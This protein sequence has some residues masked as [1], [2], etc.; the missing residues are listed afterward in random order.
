MFRLVKW[1]LDVMADDGSAAIVYAAWMDWGRM[2]ISYASV[3]QSPSSGP[4]LEA[5]T[6]RGV[7]RPRRAGSSLAWTNAPLRVRGRWHAEEPPIRQTLARN[8]SGVI[9]WQ[10]HMPR[11][12][13]AVQCG[14]VTVAGLGY[15]ESLRITIPLSQLT[16]RTLRWGHYASDRHSVVWIDWTGADERRWVWLDGQEQPG[17]T[18]K[19]S[20][21]SGLEGGD[22]L[23]L[24]DSRDVLDRQVLATV[25]GVLPVLGRRL[26][27]PLA[28]MHERKRLSRS[29][30]VRAGQPVDRGWALHEVVTW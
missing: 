28:D 7:E 22:V 15:I 5:A 27:G 29:A 9:Q 30:L 23:D 20:V 4:S 12:R 16:S 21:L 3:L 14:D 11:A 24:S 17:A 13:A 10:C 8:P 1:Y 18:L 6:I 25:G 26:V 19:D 2:H